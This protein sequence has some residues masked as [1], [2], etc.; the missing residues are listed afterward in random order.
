MCCRAFRARA[1]VSLQAAAMLLGLPGKLGMSG[2]KVW[3]A[4]LDGEIDAIR[5]Y[6]ETDVLNTFLIL[7]AVR[8]DARPPVCGRVRRP[9]R[10]ACANVC[11]A[12]GKPH[13]EE[14]LAAWRGAALKRTAAAACARRRRRRDIDDLSHEG[15]GVA[16]HEGKAVFI[17]DALPGERWNGSG[18]KRGKQLR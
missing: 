10:C 11:S 5:N 15:R 3:D 12:Q 18:A 16:H 4:Y 6:C 1:R 9:K 17:D 8:D 7:S 13:F 2:D 14:F